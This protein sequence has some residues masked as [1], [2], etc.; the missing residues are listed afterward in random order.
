MFNK[1]E[2]SKGLVQLA[3]WQWTVTIRPNYKVSATS[4]FNLIQRLA[5][6]LRSIIFYTI[7][8]DR[9]SSHKHIHLLLDKQTSKEEVYKSLKIKKDTVLYSE[10]IESPEA[11][12]NYILKHINN[13]SEHNICLDN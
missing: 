6:K 12:S 5:K 13:N 10:P 11:I 9:D 2:Y 7:E 4:G 8:K 1:E 3:N